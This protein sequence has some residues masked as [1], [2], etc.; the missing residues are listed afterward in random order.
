[1]IGAVYGTD[2]VAAG[3]GPFAAPVYLNNTFADDAN[4]MITGSPA[5]INSSVDANSL[6]IQSG[7]TIGF[8]GAQTLTIASGMIFD[9]QNATIGSTIGEGTLTT[10][11]SQDLIFDVT[12]NT[13]TVN[14][15]IAADAASATRAL[16]KAG[17]GTLALANGG[18]AI[19]DIYDLGGTIQVNTL[20]ALGNGA[21]LNLFGGTLTS[22][23]NSASYA[24]AINVGPQGGAIQTAATAGQAVT[25]TGPVTLNGRLTLQNS[26]GN[27]RLAQ[28]ALSN[29]ISGLG[30]ILVQAGGNTNRNITIFSGDNSAWAGGMTLSSGATVRLDS[31]T[32]AGTGPIVG[33]GNTSANNGTSVL[34]F[35]TNAAGATLDN[36]IR[37]I[38]ALVNWCKGPASA[39]QL[40]PA[41]AL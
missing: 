12:G 41:A 26:N 22:N 11:N 13:L 6:N 21:T 7:Q 37:D 8:I 4:V 23:L 3:A 24:Q 38:P 32:A 5:G 29:D 1:M 39:R 35:T 17:A 18:N 36:S 10:G 2:F 20:G 31:P 28:V 40:P 33:P 16:T 14:S 15:T 25:L 9:N 30:D 34:V 27:A 19:G